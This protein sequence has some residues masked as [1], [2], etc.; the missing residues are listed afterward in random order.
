MERLHLGVD[1][2][3]GKSLWVRMNYRAETGDF[4]VG[5]CYRPPGPRRLHKQRVEARIGILGGTQRLPYQPAMSLGKI[6]PQQN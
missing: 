5:V 3:P 6:M 1:E 4:I 2:E